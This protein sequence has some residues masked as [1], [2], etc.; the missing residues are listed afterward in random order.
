MT[1]N[2]WILYLKLGSAPNLP[3]S[4]QN[5]EFHC[6]KAAIASMTTVFSW[7]IA[8]TS[9]NFRQIL[10]KLLTYASWTKSNLCLQLLA[11]K[12][13]FRIYRA[14]KRTR[15]YALTSWSWNYQRENSSFTHSMLLL[16]DKLAIRFLQQRSF[17]RPCSRKIKANCLLASSTSSF[18]PKWHALRQNTMKN[19]HITLF[20]LLGRN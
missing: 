17:L 9:R 5:I 4:I 11:T 1:T 6:P 12:Y 7:K 3:L 16:P 15:A 14:N 19:N 18:A 2:W 8:K 20:V 10:M 13:F